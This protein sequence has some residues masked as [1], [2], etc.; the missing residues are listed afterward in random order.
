MLFQATYTIKSLE[1][2]LRQGEAVV[3]E[4]VV[5]QTRRRRATRRCQSGRR[6][7]FL[8][9]DENGAVVCPRKRKADGV[10]TSVQGVEVNEV[11]TSVGESFF[12]FFGSGRVCSEFSK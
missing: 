8:I 1:T 10:S 9:S 7:E 4:E 12:F 3:K 5:T 6:V 2:N 11:Q